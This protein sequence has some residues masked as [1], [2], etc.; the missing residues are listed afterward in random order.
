[1]GETM[2]LVPGACSGRRGEALV[3]RP[4]EV[5][6]RLGGQGGGMRLGEVDLAPVDLGLGDAAEL[7]EVAAALEIGLGDL[8]RGLRLAEAGLRRGE[9]VAGVEDAGGIEGGQRL[10]GLTRS[11]GCTDEAEDPTRGAG[12]QA[13]DP[14]L[15]EGDHAGGPHGQDDP[16]G[17]GLPEGQSE[18]ALA[19]GIEPDDV[20]LGRL[21]GGGRGRRRG[22]GCRRRQPDRLEK[23]FDIGPDGV[24][25][26]PAGQPERGQTNDQDPPRTEPDP[27]GCGTGCR[28]ADGC[29]RRAR[30]SGIHRCAHPATVDDLGIAGPGHVGL[31]LPQHDIDPNQIRV[32]LRHRACDRTR[33]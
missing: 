22:L 10:P 6:L 29:S 15:V 27:R 24:A 2:A 9:A 16:A 30:C 33:H 8:L 19:V 11:P 17:L 12:L 14:A 28:G 18:A 32:V 4:V 21:L 13:G 3:L 26:P 31:R 5:D 23:R 7:H 1:M 20:V 25:I